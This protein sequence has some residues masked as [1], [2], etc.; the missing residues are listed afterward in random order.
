MRKFFEDELL[1]EAFRNVMAGVFLLAIVFLIPDAGHAVGKSFFKIAFDSSWRNLG[2][3]AAAWCSLKILLLSGGV[4]FFIRALGDWME[5]L[6]KEA[7]ATV[8]SFAIVLP[9]LGLPFG[10][11]ELLKALL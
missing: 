2:D 3:W 5:A 1:N 4:V 10:L 11:Y 7:L 9:F 8:A 6:E